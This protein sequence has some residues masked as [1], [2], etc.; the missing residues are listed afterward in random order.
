MLHTLQRNHRAALTV[1]GG[2][3][4][5]IALAS[6]R[7]VPLTTLPEGLQ[8]VTGVLRPIPLALKSRGTH[9]VV[10]N[11]KE[12]YT[13]ES[14]TV[15]LSGHDGEEVTLKGTLSFNIDPRDLPVL[16]V[17]EI[18]SKA[19]V[20]E[21]IT[22]VLKLRLEVPGDW[23]STEGA[24]SGAVLRLTAS[25]SATPVLAVLRSSLKV[26]PSGS[27]VIVDGQRGVRV[28]PDSGAS[29]QIVY[30]QRSA[31]VIQ[32]VFTP[33]GAID[34]L[35]APALFQRI[36]KSVRFTGLP[37]RSSAGAGSGGT[38]TGPP[39]GGAAG[40]LCPSG[41]YCAITDTKENIGTCVKSR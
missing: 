40:I 12:T 35:S 13:A 17:T 33:G 6:C 36:L 15:S 22:R 24:G 11:G 37:S 41:S 31:E 16:T 7:P 8:E 32:F 14:T 5:L 34:P 20:R 26:L 28:L 21:V 2:F 1:L 18:V 19:F 9:V 38:L 25:G 23:Q 10:V 39:C 3:L 29:D 30:I 4:T 27:P